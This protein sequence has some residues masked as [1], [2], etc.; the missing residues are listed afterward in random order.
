MNLNQNLCATKQMMTSLYCAFVPLQTKEIK[1]SKYF[2]KEKQ[3][4]VSISL[5]GL[6]L[7]RAN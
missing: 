2:L 1:N 4:S 6:T 3:R 7:A 5:L